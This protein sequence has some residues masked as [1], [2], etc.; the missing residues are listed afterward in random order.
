MSASAELSGFVAALRTEA[1]PPPAVF[2]RPRLLGPDL[3][4]LPR[5][6]GVAW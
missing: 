2:A 5:I 6:R 1:L 4:G 3:V